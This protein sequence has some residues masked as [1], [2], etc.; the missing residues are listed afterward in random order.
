MEKADRVVKD[1]AS[2]SLQ[3]RLEAASQLGLLAD[4]LGPDRSRTELLP[5]L[6]ELMDDEPELLEQVARQV[7]VLAAKLGKAGFP[8]CLALLEAIVHVPEEAPRAAA[9]ASL[10]RMFDQPTIAANEEAI[11][12]LIRRLESTEFEGAQEC[13]AK[14]VLKVYPHLPAKQT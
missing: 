10:L 5:F 4:S 14:V 12:K 9:I 13:L 3:A 11:L 1:L 8:G 7:P 2:D 6:A